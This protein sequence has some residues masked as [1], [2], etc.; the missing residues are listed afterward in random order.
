MR[1]AATTRSTRS[2]TAA[3]GRPVTSVVLHGEGVPAAS[4][5]AVT[6]SKTAK[7]ARC[8]ACI[9]WA[10]VSCSDAVRSPAKRSRCA[11][12]R[13]AAPRASAAIWSLTRTKRRSPAGTTTRA[14]LV[15]Q[16]SAAAKRPAAVET[17]TNR[18]G[19]ASPETTRAALSS[20]TPASRTRTVPPV[21]AVASTASDPSAARAAGRTRGLP[22]AP[23]AIART[24]GP[25]DP[26]AA[27]RAPGRRGSSGAT[28]DRAL[29]P[30]EARVTTEP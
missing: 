23:S 1:F 24:S 8:A 20:I 3:P 7:P 13:T 9:P 11:W 30:R 4:S 12:G 19:T 5:C 26:R 25:P 15:V 16:S 6:T 27:I 17:K 2:A 10:T 29:R 18:T 21:L 22:A 28:T 14:W